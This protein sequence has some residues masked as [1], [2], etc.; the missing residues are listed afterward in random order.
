MKK[1]IIAIAIL[2][3]LGA[4]ITAGVMYNQKQSQKNKEE[5]NISRA[6]DSVPEINI[7]YDKEVIGK[8]DGYTMEMNS[9]HL[10][11]DIIPILPNHTSTIRNYSK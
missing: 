3:L 2:V 7:C 11:N 9:A 5:T 1:T 8:I 10:R 6:M 4:A